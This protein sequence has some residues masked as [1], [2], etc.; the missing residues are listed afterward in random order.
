MRVYIGFDDT[1]NKNANRGTGKLARW[2][3]KE[4]PE[5]CRMWGVCYCP[6]D[7]SHIK[8]HLYENP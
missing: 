5:G 3:E 7:K 8:I 2:F 4:L 1:D 6:Y